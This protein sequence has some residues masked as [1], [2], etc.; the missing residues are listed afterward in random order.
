[1]VGLHDRRGL[2]HPSLFHD[3]MKS[4]GTFA[5]KQQQAAACTNLEVTADYYP[6]CFKAVQQPSTSAPGSSDDG[7]NREM[8]PPERND[9]LPTYLCLFRLF[10]LIYSP[11][12]CLNLQQG[13]QS[14]KCITA[15]I[16]GQIIQWI[17]LTVNHSIIHD[18]KS[19]C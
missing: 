15:F 10:L 4:R 6:C 7:L 17:G 1:M 14:I 18:L 3:S 11:K 12:H 16:I 8:T 9:S 19:Q 2:F 13:K 5:D